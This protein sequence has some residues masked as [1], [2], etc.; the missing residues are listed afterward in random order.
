MS[1]NIILTPI[2]GHKLVTNSQKMTG[3]NPNLD[4]VNIN[5]NRKFGKILSIYSEDIEQKRYSDVNQGP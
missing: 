5:A 3:D 4:I 2:T 1:G